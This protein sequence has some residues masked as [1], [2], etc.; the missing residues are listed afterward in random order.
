MANVLINK[1]VDR[2]KTYD[3]IVQIEVGANTNQLKFIQDMETNFDDAN[4]ERDRIDNGDSVFTRVGDVLGT[5][6]FR[7]KN[8]VDLYD[9]VTPPTNT[10]TISFWVD[11]LIKADPAK[12]VFIQTFQAPESS[13]DKFARIKFTG[14]I[15]KVTPDR[16]DGRAIDEVIVEGEITVLTSILRQSS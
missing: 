9:S 13:G 5:F 15:M 11:K 7:T 1:E 10:L 6:R 8:S 14:R 3:G 2:T 4:L 12:L 16:I